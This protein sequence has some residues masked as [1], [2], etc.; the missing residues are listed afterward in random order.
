M[1]NAKPLRLEDVQFLPIELPEPMQTKRWRLLC[2]C[3]HTVT[4]RSQETCE[5]AGTEHWNAVHG[6]DAP[7]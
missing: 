2:R 1:A 3:G 4:A 5:I 6:A 7:I